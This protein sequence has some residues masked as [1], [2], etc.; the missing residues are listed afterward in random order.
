[1]PSGVERREGVIKMGHVQVS[2]VVQESHESSCILWA[3]APN[4]K[5]IASLMQFHK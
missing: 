2:E 4:T 1:M 3:S 5:T